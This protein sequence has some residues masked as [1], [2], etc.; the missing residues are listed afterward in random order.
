[1]IYFPKHC[2]IL[3]F[4]SLPNA[5]AEGGLLPKSF[6][7]IEIIRL[8]SCEFSHSQLW[9]TYWK[10]DICPGARHLTSQHWFW[11]KST[12]RHLQYQFM[13]KKIGCRKEQAWKHSPCLSNTLILSWLLTIRSVHDKWVLRNKIKDIK[14]KCQNKKINFKT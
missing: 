1:M 9:P 11:G 10:P 3:F 13:P 4:L 8:I 2:A 6:K 5:T 12:W 7:I 14:N